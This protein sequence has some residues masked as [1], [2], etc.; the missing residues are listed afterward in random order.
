MVGDEHE[1][2][3]VPALWGIRSMREKRTIIDN[4]NNV[5]YLCGPGDVRI[6]VP[7]G[8]TAIPIENSPSKH[9]MVVCTA[10]D[11]LRASCFEET[12]PAFAAD[13]VPT[14]N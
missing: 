13:A 8:T 3:Y 7:A 12:A 6:N 4:I 2:S 11:G 9:P 1:P 10:Y 14:S 5:I